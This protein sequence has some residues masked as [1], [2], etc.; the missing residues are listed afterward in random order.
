[1]AGLIGWI[2]TRQIVPRRARPQ[3]PEHA[4]QHRAR[5]GP[6]ATA[7]VG[8]PTQTKDRL[9][10]GPLLVREIHAQGTTRP[11]ES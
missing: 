4:V 3:D 10:D 6:R 5:L 11:R 2:A 8:A 9:E 7:A 1:M